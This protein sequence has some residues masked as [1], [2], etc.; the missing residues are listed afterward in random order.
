MRTLNMHKMLADT[1]IFFAL[2][3]YF[4]DFQFQVQRVNSMEIITSA[5]TTR[6]KEEN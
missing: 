5:F 3:V 6:K 4:R 1:V 2:K